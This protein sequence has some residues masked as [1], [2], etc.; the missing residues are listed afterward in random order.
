MSP[1]PADAPIAIFDS[2]VGGLTVLRAIR[3][4]LP[5][6]PTVYLGDT[7]RVPYGT[8]SART[9]RRYAL[10]NA[11]FLLEAVQPRLLV[12]A[13]NTASAVAM[14]ALEA[15]VD[16]PVLGVIEP[17]ARV[18]NVQSQSRTVAVAGTRGTVQSG[19]YQRALAALDPTLTVHAR[20]CPLFVPLAE[21]GWHDDPIARTVAA[22]YLADL[23]EL[24]VDTLVLGCTHYPLLAPAIADAVG[25]KIT[26]IDSAR[27]VANEVRDSLAGTATT[28]RATPPIHRCYVTDLPDAFHEVAHR[29]LGGDP[30]SPELVDVPPT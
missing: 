15:A 6:H 13:C 29:F 27:A 19:A 30:P 25:P 16:I 3:E 24:G 9:V 20:P 8:R 12:V 26:L 17:G 5:D 18:A 21:E 10:N 23:P 11:R 4:A 22:R 14:E 1:A 28:P 7:A 2:G